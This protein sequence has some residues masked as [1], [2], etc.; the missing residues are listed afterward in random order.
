MFKYLFLAFLASNVFAQVDLVDTKGGGGA[1]GVGFEQILF[2]NL[3]EGGATIIYSSKVNTVEVGSIDCVRINNL[4]YKNACTA[5]DLQNKKTTFQ[6]NANHFINGIKEL[7]K[8]VVKKVK[9]AS[10]QIHYEV[11]YIRCEYT[12]LP[13]PDYVGYYNDTLSFDCYFKKGN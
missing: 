12:L 8:S 1:D 3:T 13:P 9:D 4:H 11:K 2:D 5:V 10:G 6:F 7:D